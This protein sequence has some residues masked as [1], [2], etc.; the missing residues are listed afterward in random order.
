LKKEPFSAGN[1]ALVAVKTK[2]PK[3]Y[4]GEAIGPV[5][6]GDIYKQFEIVAE[7]HI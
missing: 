6:L 2:T 7:R 5:K 4:K 1:K 3:E